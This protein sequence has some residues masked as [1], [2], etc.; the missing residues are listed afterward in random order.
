[1]V[2]IPKI[3]HQ[4]WIGPNKRPDIWIDTFR[5]DYIASNPEYTHR[6]WT[7][8]D[9]DDL[10]DEFSVLK[11]IYNEEST[12]N[13]KSDIMRYI[14]LYKYGGI[15]I[16]ADAIWV[17]NKSF[18]SLID[19]TNSSGIFLARENELPGTG[20]CGGVFGAT[21]HNNLLYKLI[22]GIEEYV[23]WGPEIKLH[24]YRRKRRING[25]CNVIGPRYLN[26][27]LIDDNITI[28]P[29][30]YFYPVSWHTLTDI[31]MHNNI[32]IPLESY[33]LQYGYTTCNLKSA[34][35]KT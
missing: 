4:I 35:D 19:N 2:K 30:I 12:Y 3:I 27:T 24:L 11:S 32:D 34:I 9:I 33:T 18:D 14:I 15:Y 6:L 29:S 21:Q 17:N 5:K 28:Y 31:N 26:R 7:D 22:S 23:K 25:V 16:D 8:N 13:G 1:M 10:F 20:M